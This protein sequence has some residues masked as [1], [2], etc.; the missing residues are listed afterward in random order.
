MSKYQNYSKRLLPNNH[1]SIKTPFLQARIAYKKI[2]FIVTSLPSATR[3][4][5]STLNEIE[6][7]RENMINEPGG[8]KVIEEYIFP[9]SIPLI[10]KN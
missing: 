2:E 3:L 1:N 5:N 6:T 10:I 9:K 7:R 8:F 4:V